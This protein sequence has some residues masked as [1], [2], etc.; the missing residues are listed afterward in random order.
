MCKTKILL[1]SKGEK[2]RL[3][4]SGLDSL[5]LVCCKVLNDTLSVIFSVHSKV[6]LDITG[7]IHDIGHIKWELALCL[8]LAWVLVCF[9]LAKGIKSGGK[10]SEQYD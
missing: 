2:I 6:V 1:F 9:C 7:G 8:L 4:Q 5:L 10:V 3:F